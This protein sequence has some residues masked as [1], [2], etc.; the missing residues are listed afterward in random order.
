[1]EDTRFDYLAKAVGAVKSRRLTLRAALGTVVLG[2]LGLSLPNVAEAAR[3]RRPPS[4]C[5]ICKKGKKTK[6]GKR[7]PGKIKPKANGTPCQ[8]GQGICQ[9]GRCGVQAAPQQPEPPPPGNVCHNVNDSCANDAECC[10][11]SCGKAFFDPAL[12]CCNPSGTSC[13]SG[14]APQCCSGVCETGNNLNQCA[15]K[16]SGADCN[17]NKQCCSGDC[18]ANRTCL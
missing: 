7:K 12:R 8:G 9:D 3:C 10:N 2:S 11:G 6:S 14:S 16:G 18:Q 1:V 13:S 5:E 15:C 4:E 17:Q